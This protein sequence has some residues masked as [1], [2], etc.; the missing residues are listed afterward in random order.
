MGELIFDYKKEFLI[1]TINSVGFLRE[2]PSWEAFP[3]SFGME[4]QNGRIT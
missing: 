1:H 2:M 3:V 4:E